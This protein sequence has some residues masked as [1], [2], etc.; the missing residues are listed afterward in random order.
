MGD[1]FDFQDGGGEGRGRV[2]VKNSH[3]HT[4]NTFELFLGI[5]NRRRKETNK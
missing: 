2:K 3:T 1:L 5:Q 4:V